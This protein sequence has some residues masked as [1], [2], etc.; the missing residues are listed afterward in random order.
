M[1]L[2]WTNCLKLQKKSVVANSKNHTVTT[3]FIARGSGTP[4]AGDDAGHLSVF[5]ENALPKPLAFD[6]ETILTDYFRYRSGVSKQVIFNLD[7]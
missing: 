5:S 6:H 3:V 7:G 4:M 2:L 1:L